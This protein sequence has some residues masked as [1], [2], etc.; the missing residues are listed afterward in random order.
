MLLLLISLP[1]VILLFAVGSRLIGLSA[2]NQ[3]AM[4][5]YDQGRYESSAEQSTKLLDDNVIEPWIPYFNRGDALAGQQKYTDA[6]DDFEKALELAPADRRCDVR[7]NLAL[8][9]ELLGDIYFQGGYLQGAILL[10]QTAQAVIDEG[11]DECPP[12]EPAGQAL[13]EADPRIQAKIDAA[14]ERLD[15]PQEG[16]GDE[17]STQ[18]DKLDDL[19]DQGQQGAQEKADGDAQDRGEGSGQTGSTVKP[20]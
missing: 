20:W 10:Y 12:T 4:D 2:T 1:V 3:V 7:L 16:E 15:E 17:P 13:G 11:A 5:L 6:V 9:W 19:Q 8:S 18:E 14:Q